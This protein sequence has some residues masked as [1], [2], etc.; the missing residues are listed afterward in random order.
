MV[1]QEAF[2]DLPGTLRERIENVHVVVEDVPSD[3]TIRSL[4]M[5]NRNLLL[6]LYEGIPLTK[7]GVHYGNS[8]VVPDKVTLYQ[9]NIEA[10]SAT[11]AILREKIREVLIHEIG[12][13]YG[14]SEEELRN[15]GY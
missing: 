13:Y 3:S 6:G 2:D 9:K 1:A 4:G 5:R 14:M 8:P 15:A 10:V 12:H 7:R 11:E